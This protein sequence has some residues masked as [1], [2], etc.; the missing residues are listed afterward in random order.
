MHTSYKI[1]YVYLGLRNHCI[2]WGRFRL[3]SLIAHKLAEGCFL[4]C[5]DQ[6]KIPSNQNKCWQCMFLQTTDMLRLD[7]L[8][9]FKDSL[10]PF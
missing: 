2:K 6:R 5:V 10:G 3:R 7:L 1:Q 8:I 9:F 4:V